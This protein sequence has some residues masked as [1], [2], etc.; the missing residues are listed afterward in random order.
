MEQFKELG[1][2]QE[3]L[4]LVSY[5]FGIIDG[6]GSY[7]LASDINKHG[8]RYFS[9]Q[10]NISNANPG[11]IDYCIKAF[12]RLDVAYYVWTPKKHGKEK[13]VLYRLCVKGIKRMAKFLAVAAYFPHAK[14]RQAKLLKNFCDLRLSIDP[15]KKASGHEIT[16][17]N[18]EV[19]FKNELGRLNKEYNTR[20][21]ILRDYTLD[22][23]KER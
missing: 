22:S 15:K 18:A 12:K 9:P 7:Q 6:E 2:Q 21:R 11:I 17:T 10:L 20:G 8:R 14:I 13:C 1:N 5:L 23:L 19:G 3:R 4:S 16:Y